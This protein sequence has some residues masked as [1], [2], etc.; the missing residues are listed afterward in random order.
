M[1]SELELQLKLC[2]AR[3]DPWVPKGTVM[4][5]DGEEVVWR[6]MTDAEWNKFKVKY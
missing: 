4:E 2:C 3:P 1:S 5:E 6:G